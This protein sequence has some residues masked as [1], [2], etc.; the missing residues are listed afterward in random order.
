M[1][2]PEEVLHDV[3]G[4]ASFRN[5]QKRVIDAALAGFDVIVVQ[6]TGAGKSL[7]FQVPALCQ[8]GAT[9]VVSPLLALMHD[10]VR[11]L[12]QHGVRCG[13]Y[14]SEASAAERRDMLGSLCATKDTMKLLYTSPEQV[15]HSQ[16][17]RKAIKALARSGRLQRVVLDEAHCVIDWGSSFRYAHAM[18]VF[19]PC[20]SPGKYARRACI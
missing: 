10:Q 1:R 4:F 13:V 17:L 14:S 11:S 5:N 7:C 9:V 8:V 20:A 2:D 3:F 18:R 19:S 6:G 12:R 15:V 16:S